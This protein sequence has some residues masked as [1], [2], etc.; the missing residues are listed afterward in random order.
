MPLPTAVGAFF[1]RRRAMTWKELKQAVLYKIFAELD[2]KLDDSDGKIT[3]YI[4]AM[5]QAANEAMERICSIGRPYRQYIEVGRDERHIDMKMEAYDFKSFGSA[6]EIYC[7]D[8]EQPVRC[9]G[10]AFGGHMLS[11]PSSGEKFMVFYN[12]FPPH[13]ND[14][15]P[16]DYRLPLDDDCNVLLPLYIAGEIYKEDHAGLAT[17]WMNE[18]EAGLESLQVPTPG[19]VQ[20]TFTNVN[21]W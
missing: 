8:G 10:T 11:L 16:D 15:T 3:E 21:G 2:G 9:S 20:E 7:I 19:V 12:A 5:P 18:F 6:V 14:K 4:H 17:L 1:K 13:I